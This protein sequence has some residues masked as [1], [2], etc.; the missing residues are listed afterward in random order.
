VPRF[1]PSGLEQT[2]G[3]MIAEMHTV[4]LAVDVPA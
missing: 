3:R 2:H 1:E 4:Y